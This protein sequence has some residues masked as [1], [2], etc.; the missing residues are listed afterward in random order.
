MHL[1]LNPATCSLCSLSLSLSLS[2]HLSLSRVIVWR[3]VHYSNLH[4]SIRFIG[5]FFVIHYSCS[6]SHLST[7]SLKRPPFAKRALGESNST[8]FP[9]DMTRMCV[10]SKIVLSLWATVKVVEPAKSS[11]KT[12]W[13]RESASASIED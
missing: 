3:W 6:S 2:I 8:A 9:S 1:L 11:R 7:R 13:M 12:R 10:E 4:N 5:F